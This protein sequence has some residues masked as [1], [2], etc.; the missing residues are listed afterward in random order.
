MNP[1]R[2]RLQGL[3]PQF[4]ELVTLNVSHSTPGGLSALQDLLQTLHWKVMQRV[5]LV[6]VMVEE[7]KVMPAR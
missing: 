3:Q 6:I 7:R 1:D 5:V 4:L 2:V